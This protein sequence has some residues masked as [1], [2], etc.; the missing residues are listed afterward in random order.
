MAYMESAV[1]ILN[2]KYLKSPM[3]LLVKPPESL[4]RPWT[5]IATNRLK[6][7]TLLDPKYITYKG[8]VLRLLLVVWK[9]SESN[10]F[11]FFFLQ[12]LWMEISW[13]LID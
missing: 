5:S 3:S 2:R 6:G 11:I 7:D 9:D 12:D 8:L 1:S 13:Q 10:I 4:Q